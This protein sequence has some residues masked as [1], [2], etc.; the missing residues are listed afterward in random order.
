MTICRHFAAGLIL[1]S[2]AFLGGCSSSSSTA[3][4]EPAM[5]HYEEGSLS[6]AKMEAQQIYQRK[7][8][9]RWEA[10]WVIGLCN[11]RLG[12]MTAARINFELA[13]DSP[14]TELAARARAMLGQNLME[15]GQ[16]EAAAIQF[17]HAWP[18]LTGEDRRQ[19][20][21]HA[22]NAWAAAG[23]QDQAERWQSL[24]DTPE[25]VAS[26]PSTTTSTTS[27]ARGRFT[28]QS[29]AYRDADGAKRARIDLA[30][31]AD[32]AGFDEPVIRTRTDRHGATLYLVQMGTFQSRHAAQTAMRSLRDRDLIVVASY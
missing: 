21:E 16:P 1:T 27:T 29:G 28:I 13:S 23:R 2:V 10:A 3:S 32:N 18:N 11:Q 7:D 26:D 5:Q 8:G 17:E 4:L 31:R 12:R 25:Y 22:S 6:L 14:D 20:A 19:C 15:S 30:S 9:D 24:A